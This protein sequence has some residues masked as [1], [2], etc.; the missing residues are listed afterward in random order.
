M[1]P[2]GIDGIVLPQFEEGIDYNGYMARLIDANK[3]DLVIQAG[4]AKAEPDT[5]NKLK[6]LGWEGKYVALISN[7]LVMWPRHIQEYLESP[8]EFVTIPSPGSYE[9]NYFV[10]N[11]LGFIN[12]R[13]PVYT[14]NGAIGAI[15]SHKIR[16]FA[17]G[18]AT[19]NE[20]IERR[21]KTW[22]GDLSKTRLNRMYMS[23]SVIPNRP[24]SRTLSDDATLDRKLFA[25]WGGINEATYGL[26][27]SQ[28]NDNG[29]N[30]KELEIGQHG[31][32]H[33]YRRPLLVAYR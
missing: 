1:K 32:N 12:P 20:A 18:Q 14:V 16:R 33:P 26:L 23:D 25:D 24:V 13:N 7:I 29:W 8:D 19:T 5:Y 6:E 22:L 9:D 4:R 11:I 17:R 3:Q 15:L 2:D 31:S 28:L 10:N 27:L 30:V 21:V